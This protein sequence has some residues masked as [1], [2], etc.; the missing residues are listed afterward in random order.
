MA[1]PSDLNNDPIDIGNFLS[2]LRSFVLTPIHLVIKYK[3]TVLMHV[4]V[5]LLLAC[6]VRFALPPAY[7]ATFII[8]PSDPKERFHLRIIGD[9]AT[10]AKQKNHA[11]IANLLQIDAVIAS[12]LEAIELYNPSFK[13]S[14]D[15]IN[16]TEVGLVM[17]SNKNFEV[18]QNALLNYLHNNPYFKK[19]RDVQVRQIK[20]TEN[21]IKVDLVELDSLKQLQQEALRHSAVSSQVAVSDFLDPV[22]AYTLAIDRV[23]KQ[24][25]LEGQK[26]FIDNFQLIKAT[27]AFDRPSFPPRL[28]VLVLL[29]FGAGILTAILY[30][31]LK[32]G[33]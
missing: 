14:P 17:K 6:L 8:R 30:V 11:A 22:A 1:H 4:C 10:L 29:A 28:L 5:W 23:Y 25:S 33:R 12:E 21:R 13:Q 15:S 27:T 31:V 24:G 16:F 18:I 7:R 20:L 9:V 3:T 19:I 26:A 32:H 2:R